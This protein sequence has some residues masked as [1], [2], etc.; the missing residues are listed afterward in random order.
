MESHGRQ[1]TVAS[2]LDR[3]PIWVIWSLVFMLAGAFIYY[4][5]TTVAAANQDARE[6]IREAQLASCER[7][8][9]L[10]ISHNAQNDAL[11]KVLATAA[12]ANL[13]EG[14][15]QVALEYTN[16]AGSFNDIPLTDCEKAYPEEISTA[17]L[18][19]EVASIGR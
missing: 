7:V 4:R 1:G 8:N 17:G 13:A 5:L 10:R 2:V 14:N 19:G 3:T 16:L 9:D 18:A 6:L 11:R 12:A 15:D